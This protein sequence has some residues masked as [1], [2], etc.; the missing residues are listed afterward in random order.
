LE[1][2]A[3]AGR[4]R[5]LL[6]TMMR[7]QEI[8]IHE[9]DRSLTYWEAKAEIETKYRTKLV[10]KMDKLEEKMLEE[11]SRKYVSYEFIGAVR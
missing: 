10:L 2:K 7:L 6:E 11:P 1:K 4:F 8:D 3:L 9:L 5:W